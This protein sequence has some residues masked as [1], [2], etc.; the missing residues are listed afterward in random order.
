MR[1]TDLIGE[2]R[3]AHDVDKVSFDASDYDQR[4]GTPG[5]HEVLPRVT[6]STAARATILPPD[7]FRRFENDSFWRHPELNPR[8]VLVV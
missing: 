1:C 4:A 8:K 3:F 7:L 6:A 2:P 5:L